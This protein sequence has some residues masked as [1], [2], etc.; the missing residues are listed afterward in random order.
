MDIYIEQNLGELQLKIVSNKQE[1][2]IKDMYSLFIEIFGED[3]DPPYS[4]PMFKR[5]YDEGGE[6]NLPIV[7]YINDS[8][9]IFRYV[10]FSKETKISY[11]SWGGIIQKY[12]G[13][14]LYPYFIEETNKILL[15]LGQEVLVNE[16]ENPDKV[17]HKDIAEGRLRMFKNKLDYRFVTREL[18]YLRN[19]EPSEITENNELNIQDEYILGLKFLNSE[20][21]NK[22][23]KNDKIA[24]PEVR[25]LYLAIRDFEFGFTKE[26]YIK[27][28]AIKKYLEI[29]DN[30]QDQ[31]IKF[32]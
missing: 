8:P 28:P 2:L 30:Y 31:Y 22:V 3:Y 21:M 23:V 29:I 14:S 24:K 12:R 26:S 13:K 7:G 6:T 32:D 18:P 16:V 27:L 5:I 1:E 9:A 19:D 17:E 20:Y 4:Y 15:D 11:V 10:Q 25:R